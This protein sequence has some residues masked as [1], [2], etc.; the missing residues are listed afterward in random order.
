[1]NRLLA[2][3]LAALAIAF[4]VPSPAAAGGSVGV[5]T[6]MA[7]DP[8]DFIIGLHFKTGPL[9]KDLH[10]VPS[11]EAG[12]G[13]VTMIAAN[14]DLHYIFNSKSK[15]APYAG[16]GLTLNWFD[17]DSGSD[18]EF[19]GSLLGGILLGQTSL[20]EMFFETKIGLGDVPDWKFIVGWN[21]H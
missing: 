7:L 15:L 6:G 20:G 18:T 8:D 9:A 4:I 21:M 16:G 11:V 10:F 17:F 12:F 5:R 3:L 1:M 2:G 13:D 19:G 14:A